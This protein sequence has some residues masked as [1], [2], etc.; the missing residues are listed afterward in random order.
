MIPKDKALK[1]IKNYD[2]VP[3][4]VSDQVERRKSVNL[5]FLK[6]TL[7][8]NFKIQALPIPFFYT[9]HTVL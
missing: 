2:T 4:S 5:E 6:R 9:N 7:M 8:F 1:L 3:Q